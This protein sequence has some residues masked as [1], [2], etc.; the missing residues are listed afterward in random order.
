MI[1]PV[2]NGEDRFWQVFRTSPVATI[3]RSLETGRVVDVNERYEQLV[4]YNRDELIGRNVYE[5]NIWADLA[6]AERI[7]GQLERVGTLRDVEGHFRRKSGE[8]RDVLICGDLAVVGGE[9]MVVGML[10]DITERKRMERQLTRS[11]E[12]LRALSARLQKIREEERIRIAR[13]LHDE[14]G[15]FLTVLKLDLSALGS[16]AQDLS[17]ETR[18]RLD[19]M[20]STIVSAIGAVRRI[21]SDLRPSLLDHIGLGA[22]IEWQLAEFQSKTGIRCA[23]LGGLEDDE[24]LDPDRAT[25][26][27]RILQE[28]LTNV[29]RHAGAKQVSV[30]LGADAERL[31]LEIQDDGRGIDPETV[32]APSSLGLLGMQERV[33]PFGGSVEVRGESG[34]GTTVEVSV[35]LSEATS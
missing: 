1:A 15:G 2:E 25:A 31:H 34:V 19:A 18:R 10:I 21:C 33:F 14:I 24:K 16:Q 32:G 6:E 5:L 7:L 26:A 3:L 35:P 17:S 13:E 4:G 27:F 9:K 20:G 12:Q 28:A 11:R 8:L 23:L 30:R 29:A 22:A